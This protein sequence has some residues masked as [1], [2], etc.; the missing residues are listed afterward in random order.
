MP[1]TEIITIINNSGKI[2]S[3]GKHLVSIFKDAQ[4]TYKEKKQAVK[5]ERAAARA[6][7]IQRAKTFDVTPRGITDGYGDDDNDHVH[8]R[9]AIRDIGSGRRRSQDDERSHASSRHTHRSSK[10]T[11]RHRSPGG[12][13]RAGTLLTE[14]NLKALTEVSATSPSKAAYRSPYAETAPRD[15]QMSRPTLAHAATMPIP[16][17]V[18]LPT[19]T[20]SQRRNPLPTSRSE[21][22]LNKKKSIDMHLAYGNIP[23]DLASRHDLDPKHDDEA[24]DPQEAEAVTLI[25]R[26]ES[27]LEDAHC[28]HHTASSMIGKLQEKPEAAAAVALTLAE[29]SALLGK[30]SP[31][32]LGFIKGGSPAIFA[33]LASPQF[34]IGTSIAVGVTVVMFGGWKIVKR[35]Q[36]ANAAKAMEKPF[37]MNTMPTPDQGPAA[38]APTVVPS[39]VSY[40]EA[41]VLEEELSTIES[42]RRGIAP[43]G[44]DEAADVELMSREAERALRRKHYDDDDGENDDLVDPD[45]SI[46]RVGLKSRRHRSSRSHHGGSSS[47]GHR[48]SR[49]HHDDM[50]I[51]ERKS[52][53]SYNKDGGRTEVAESVRSHRSHRSSKSTR[54]RAT[55]KTIEERK[56]EEEDG[57]DGE[58]MDVVLRPKKNNML[59]QLFK[60]KKDKDDKEHRTAVSVLV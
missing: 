33:L 41:L 19:P 5:I 52:S 31:A 48:S 16:Q 51:P 14:D 59:K 11:H 20:P 46:S 23:P 57:E 10:R 47:G 60:K 26:I 6:P 7:G 35:I 24:E 54:S 40:D 28:V 56:D 15:M 34:L 53:K 44:E 38:P 45:D 50:E 43:F 21:T 4:A 12:A 37:E 42:W 49:R 55:V 58:T 27:L 17:P 8:N 1:A 22:S 18:P 29:L 2:I 39:A 3:T 13:S 32:F 25:D 9:R 36:A 30:M